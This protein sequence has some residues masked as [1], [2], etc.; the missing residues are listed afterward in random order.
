MRRSVL[1]ALAA[2]LFVAADAPKQKGAAADAPKQKGAAADAPKQK[3]DDL[4][5]G[6][7]YMVRLEKPD[8]KGG[9]EG[10]DFPDTDFT[11]T[12]DH[13]AITSMKEG[14]TLW[15]GTYYLDAGNSPGAI[16]IGRRSGI[17]KQ[18][19]YQRRGDNLRLCLDQP[20]TRR[21]TRFA[22]PSDSKAEVMVFKREKTEQ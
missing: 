6:T 21:P 8:G 9:R 14:K 1:L 16:D 18:G 11:L 20:G 22:P 2:S 10:F 12:F 4:L 7:W 3:E 13:G 15:K 17:F 19:I 5:Q